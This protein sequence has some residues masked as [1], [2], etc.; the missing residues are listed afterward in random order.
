[1]AGKE[2]A[3]TPTP[4]YYTVIF[5]SRRTD[6]DGAAYQALADRMV[7][8]ASSRPGFLGLDSARGEDGI[9]ITVSY[10]ASEEAIKA[11]KADAEHKEAQRLGRERFYSEFEVRVARVER[12]YGGPKK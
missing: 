3:R 5:T 6:E 4:P 10:W 2:L 1:M 9:G 12:A 11:W 7:E 8:L